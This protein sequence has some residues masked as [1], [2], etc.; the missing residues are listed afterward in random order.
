MIELNKPRP[1]TAE[2][3]IEGKNVLLKNKNPLELLLQL[4]LR[5]NILGFK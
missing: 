1:G 2:A 4:S 3:E 5:S